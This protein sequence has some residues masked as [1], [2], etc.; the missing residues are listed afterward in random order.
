MKGCLMALFAFAVLGVGVPIVPAVTSDLLVQ[1]ERLATILDMDGRDPRPG[2]SRDLRPQ[3]P[4]MRALS[5]S[6]HGFGSARS[7]SRR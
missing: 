4:R 6:W 7:N 3:L 5:S 1:A 2:D